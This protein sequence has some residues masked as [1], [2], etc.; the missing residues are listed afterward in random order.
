MSNGVQIARMRVQGLRYIPAQFTVQQGMP[1]EWHID[2]TGTAGCAQVL[3][4]PKLGLREYLPRQGE[5]VI[6]FTPTELGTIPFSCGMGMTTRG[7]A[8][9]VI[10]QKNNIQ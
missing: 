7:A 8:F 6:T 3:I 9:T 5:K 10:P 4:A 1:V 2:A